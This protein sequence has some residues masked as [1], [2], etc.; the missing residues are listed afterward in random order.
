MSLRNRYNPKY[1]AACW[2]LGDASEVLNKYPATLVNAPT[3]GTGP[4]GTQCIRLDGNT[5]HINCGDVLEH[6]E[7]DCLESVVMHLALLS[8]KATLLVINTG[9]AAKT[10]QDGRNA[11]LIQEGTGWWL[12]ALDDRWEWDNLFYDGGDFMLAGRPGVYESENEE[13]MSHV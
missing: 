2:K 10:L 7:P 3:W 13:G 6:V 11:H 4:K 5:S 12:N 1:L 8:K 9:P